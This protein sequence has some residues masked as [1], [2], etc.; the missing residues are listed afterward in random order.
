MASSKSE[1]AEA[2]M[3]Q[4]ELTV[5]NSFIDGLSAQLAEKVKYGMSFPKDYNYTNELMGAYLILKDTTD[6]NG[7]SVLQSCS[8]ASVANTLMEMVNNGL[9]MQKKQCYPVA[10]GGKLQCSISVYGYTCIARRYG[11]LKISAMC[12]YDKDEFSYHIEDGEIVIDK[13][14]QKFESLDSGNIIGAYAIVRMKDG[15]KHVEL[16]TKKMIET[17]WRQGYGYKA[18]GNGTHQKFEDQM[19]MKTVKNRALKYIVRTYGTPDETDLVDKS[20]DIEKT[21]TLAEDVEYDIAN[22]ANTEEFEP[23][24]EQVEIEEVIDATATPKQASFMEGME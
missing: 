17:S 1:L 6:K 12:I 11:L 13:H 8:Q 7:K 3:K 2:G 9:S 20:E 22:N 5:N 18:D 19:C 10:Y 24:Y 4:A 23:E 16:M 14:V 15:T 21:D